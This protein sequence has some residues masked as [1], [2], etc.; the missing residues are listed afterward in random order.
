MGSS[1][2]LSEDIQ[3]RGV[4]DFTKTILCTFDSREEA[5]CHEVELHEELD[6][7]NHKLFYNR[8]NARREF[9]WAGQQHSEETRKVIR[10][11]RK[12]Q[13]IRPEQI[14]KFRETWSQKT[15][16]EQEAYRA[17]RQKLWQ[18]K[19]T[20][21]KEQFRSKM[22]D[23]VTDQWAR[24]SEDFVRKRA[25][26]TRR[27]RE[28]RTDQEKAQE[29]LIRSRAQKQSKSQKT[30]DEIQRAVAK[31]KAT[32]A[33]RPESWHQEIRSKIAEKICGRKWYTNGSVSKMF[34]ESDVPAGFVPGR[35]K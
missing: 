6:V 3:S 13:K 2:Y 31:R 29:F 17:Y 10:E 30:K 28:S 11:K 21:E 26:K 27:T 16:E 9:S 22:S 4:D 19:S 1:K 8:Y 23:I 32:L 24:R 15:P 25:E 34:F 35:K 33:S 18:M 7:Q 20:E 5:E 12:K 14:E